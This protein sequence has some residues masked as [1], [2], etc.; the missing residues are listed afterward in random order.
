MMERINGL[1]D[2]DGCPDEV[3]QVRLE[4]AKPIVLKGVY[5]LTGSAKLDPN[6]EDILDNVV[7]TLKANMHIEIEIRGHTDNTGGAARNRQ[8]SLERAESVKAYLVSKG[9]NQNRIITKGF[10]PYQPLMSN[11]TPENRARNRRIEF[12]RIK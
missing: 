8:L 11:D 6:S 9:I 10:G 4:I 3:P 5:F 1:D 12:Y 7:E 2:E